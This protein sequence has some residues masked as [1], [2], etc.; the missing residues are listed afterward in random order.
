VSN[1]VRP[2]KAPRCPQPFS[3]AD[4]LFGAKCNECKPVT[5]RAGR[6]LCVHQA[7]VGGD[8]STGP[9]APS[10]DGLDAGSPRRGNGFRWTGH[11]VWIMLITVQVRI[12]HGEVTMPCSS[13]SVTQSAS[14]P[15]FLSGSSLL[16]FG[17]KLLSGAGLPSTQARIHATLSVALCLA[18]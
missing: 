7:R 4:R 1:Y 17:V 5:R 15:R 11:P 6:N 10:A 9:E 13:S 16:A 3:G 14:R 2:G 8:C 18:I 12:D